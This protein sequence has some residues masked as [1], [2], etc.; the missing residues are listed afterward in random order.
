MN[1]LHNTAAIKGKPKHLW[2]RLSIWSLKRHDNLIYA[3]RMS[4][5]S[6]SAVVLLAAVIGK[7]DLQTALRIL[8]FGG[9]GIVVLLTGLVVTRR[10]ILLAI[11]D[12]DLRVEAHQALLALIRSKNRVPAGRTE[13]RDPGTSCVDFCRQTG[14]CRQ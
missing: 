2:I 1:G 9:L 5:L 4:M 3:L 14:E 7:L 13:V 11:D 12:P 10:N 8:A 6:F